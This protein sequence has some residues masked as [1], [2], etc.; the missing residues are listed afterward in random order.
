[1]AEATRNQKVLK[2]FFLKRRQNAHRG[3][4]GIQPERGVARLRQIRA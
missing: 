2:R 4:G 3:A 1:M